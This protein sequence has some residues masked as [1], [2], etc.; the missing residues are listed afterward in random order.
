[1]SELLLVN[2]KRRKSRGK[3]RMSALQAQYFG[4][5]AKRRRSK[6]RVTR[7]ASNPKRRHKRRS[8]VVAAPVHRRRRSHSRRR[9]TRLRRNPMRGFGGFSVK[10]F[11]ND[12]LIPAGVGAAGALAVDVALG[13]TAAYIPVSLQT[14]IMHTGV[15]LAAAVGIGMVAG[16]SMGKKFGEEAM[17]GAITVT[18]YD[19]LKSQVKSI[20]PTLPLSG[21]NMGWVSP[22]MQIGGLGTYV[23]SDRAYNGQMSG[24][25]YYVGETDADYYK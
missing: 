15:K 2:P 25:G 7:L 20:M 23:G 9:V 10:R 5:R 19:L 13:Y 16:A 4:P 3:R 24:L 22:G 8:A 21:Y 14:G 11:L 1:M 6:R 18:L 12:T 17:A